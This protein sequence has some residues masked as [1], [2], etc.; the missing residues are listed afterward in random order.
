MAK[1]ILKHSDIIES[2]GTFDALF[3]NIARLKKELK[4]LAAARKKAIGAI[5]PNDE[6]AVED[7]IKDVDALVAA[8]K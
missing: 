6:K 7:A 2:D 8:R 1:S 4:A 5:N 3:N